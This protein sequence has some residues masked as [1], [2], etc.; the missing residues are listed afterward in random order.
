MRDIV[1]PPSSWSMGKSIASSVERQKSI[2]NWTM[3][4]LMLLLAL[5]P[6]A[7]NA[8][9]ESYYVTLMTRALIFAL[10]AVGLNLIL[11][12]GGLVSFGHSAYLGIGAYTVGIMM[13]QGI[14]N[15]WAQLA[16]A[17]LIGT[18]VSGIIGGL[19]LR[20][21]GVGFIMITLAFAQL[22]YFFCVGLRDYGGDDGFSLRGF[23]DLGLFHLGNNDTLY[24]TVLAV[25]A[26]TLLW[27]SRLV[28]ARFGM[29]I[30]G[31][32]SNE[33][34]MTALGFPVFRYQ[35]AA[36]VL[37]A[38]ICVVAGFFIVNLTRYV[39]PA[40]MQWTVS[41]ELIVMVV[42]GGIATI[43][44]PVVGA[45]AIV[46]FEEFASHAVFGL[47]GD[48]DAFIHEHWLGTLGIVILIVALCLKQGLYGSLVNRAKRRTS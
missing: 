23:S 40:Y 4:I 13:D 24:Y 10:A 41:G 12:Y 5:V 47:P 22:L 9:G 8:M 14:T 30:Q 35:W 19:S 42:V 20:V 16:V 33:R 15:A 32:K 43:V 38:L 37:S 31:C 46:L 48:A 17:L 27:V 11:G 34:R 21:K 25:L 44:G 29:V 7:A 6:F 28:S 45:I 1:N 18:L 3:P 26:L 36:Y 2:A 39:S